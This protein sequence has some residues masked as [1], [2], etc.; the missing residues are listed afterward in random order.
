M[1]NVSDNSLDLLNKFDFVRTF[2]AV[3]KNAFLSICV[4]LFLYQVI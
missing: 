3:E 2:L 4:I 1:Y